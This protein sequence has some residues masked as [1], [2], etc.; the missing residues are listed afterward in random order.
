MKNSLKVQDN[1]IVYTFTSVVHVQEIIDSWK[2]IFSKYDNLQEFKGILFDF[3]QA[4]LHHEEDNLSILTEFLKAYRDRLEDM[5]VAMVLDHPMVT[6][7]IMLDRILSY[8]ELRPFA[9]RQGAVNWII[10]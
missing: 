3:L 4:D 7:A 9:T 8:V 5:K 10:I 6:Y 1:I 2:E